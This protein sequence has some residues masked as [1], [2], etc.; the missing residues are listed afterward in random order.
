MQDATTATTA[1]KR[2]N[3]K[4][5]EHDSSSTNTTNINIITNTTTAVA[6][7]T[8]VGKSSY[9]LLVLEELL[10]LLRAE[11]NNQWA[12]QL[13]FPLEAILAF[14]LRQVMPVIAV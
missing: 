11:V 13:L 12:A 9:R 10:R 7:T 5:R 1:T 6:T 8:F 14:Q 2:T 3:N 4:Q